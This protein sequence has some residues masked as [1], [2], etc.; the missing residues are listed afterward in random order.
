M[1]LVSWQELDQPGHEQEREEFG[2]LVALGT[3][4][5]LPLLD[6]LDGYMASLQQPRRGR[7]AGLVQTSRDLKKSQIEKLGETFATTAD[8]TTDGLQAWITAKVK[9]DDASKLTVHKYI[10][11]LRDYLRY[12]AKHLKVRVN[13]KWDELDFEGRE[14]L[15]KLPYPPAAVVKFEKI[16]RDRGDQ[17][18]AGY[19]CIARYTGARASEIHGLRGGD[20]DLT[21]M[22]I[23]VRGTK[24]K[25]A[26][27]VCPIHADLLPVLTRM[28]EAT[29]SGPLFPG[30]K[31]TALTQ[32]FKR[33]K[34]KEKARDGQPIYG[35]LHDFHSIRRTIIKMFRDVGAREEIVASFVGHKI[36]TITYGLYA[37][38]AVPLAVQAETMALL[39]YP[40]E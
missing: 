22:A 28:T 25:S 35:E 8:V 7:P 32:A 36:K 27:R 38:L 15:D 30:I 10:G 31:R 34:V 21:A 11:S 3:G 14:K 9:S 33:L 16:A 29:G 20:I 4:D 5:Y 2:H 13:V 17:Q 39:S 1:G 18:L 23:N 19:I 24:N 37:G 6:G 40:V 12:V 26:N